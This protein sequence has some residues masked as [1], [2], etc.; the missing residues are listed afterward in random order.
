MLSQSVMYATQLL[1]VL[2]R[3]PDQAMLVRDLA[4][5]AHVPAPYLSKIIQKL[6][7][8]GVVTTQRGVGGGVALAQTPET[9]TLYDVCDALDDP[10]IQ[11]Q[12]MIS[13]AECTDDRA[14]P[15]H[16]FWSKQRHELIA[17]LKQHS[18]FSTISS[19]DSQENQSRGSSV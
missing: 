12:C 14:C 10:V 7:R 17:F 13:T 1:T 8:K 19:D 2:A 16:S 11:P 6:V 5:A 3:D 9:I 4:E 15:C 18:I